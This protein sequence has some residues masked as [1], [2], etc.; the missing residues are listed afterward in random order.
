MPGSYI[1]LVSDD[2]HLA[3]EASYSFPQDF[4]VKV[5]RDTATAWTFMNEAAPAVAVV[6]IRSGNSGG[7]SFAREMSQREILQ[8]VPILMLLERPQDEWLAKQA[9]SAATRVQPIEASDLVAET[10]AL[11]VSTPA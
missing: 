1:L 10:M 8:H 7:F 5:A 4:E 2:Q 9:G 3:E 6:E 11:V